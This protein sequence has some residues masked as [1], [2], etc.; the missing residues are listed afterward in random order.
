MASTIAV[1]LPTE[2]NE[3][4]RKMMFD[5]ALEAFQKAGE[6]KALPEFMKLGEACEYLSVS[7]VTMDR[8]IRNHGLKASVIGGITRVSKRDVIEFMKAHQI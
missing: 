4:L 1:E 3:E 5:T 7:R 8:L 6:G 2:F